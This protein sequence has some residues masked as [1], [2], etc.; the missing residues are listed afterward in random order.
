MKNRIP[1]VSNSIKI[2]ISHFLLIIPF[3]IQSTCVNEE[4]NT[5]FQQSEV[6]DPGELAYLDNLETSDY[7]AEDIV[8]PNGRKLSDYLQEIDP[9]LYNM[10][11]HPIKSTLTSKTIFDKH[12]FEQKNIL[13]ARMLGWALVLTNRD[14]F[15]YPEEGPNSP[16]QYGLAYS[17]GQKDHTNRQKPPAGNLTICTD[18]LYGLDCS[19]LIYQLAASAGLTLSHN[20]IGE[21]NAQFESD[22]LNWVKA[23]K[24]STNYQKL[25]MEV[26]GKIQITDFQ[27]GDMI[28]WLNGDGVAFHVGIVLYASDKSGLAVFMSAGC[29]RDCDNQGCINNHS[30]N[31]GPRQ[32]DLGDPKYFNANYKV[33]R[34]KAD[35]FPPTSVEIIVDCTAIYASYPGYEKEDNFYIHKDFNKCTVS[36]N[37]ITGRI[38]DNYYTGGTHI[39]SLEMEFDPV[40][41]V[42]KDF[43]IKT[44]IVGPS[45]GD[46]TH[47][48]KMLIKKKGLTM[49]C[50]LNYYMGNV[51]GIMFSLNGPSVVSYLDV[52]L[53][54]NNRELVGMN[55][56]VSVV[57]LKEL[58]GGQSSSMSFFFPLN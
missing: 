13:L 58:I 5:S 56:V 28:F 26:L 53:E 47:Y 20:P 12:P 6:L 16:Q 30:S 57:K 17:Y 1:H 37:K 21:C 8:L 49:Q 40:L 46:Y 45:I 9:D 33:L 10:I 43:R 34:I 14:L 24:K 4:D 39:D 52:T 48:E 50:Q 2:S 11:N 44:D 27:A 15:E 31:R 18:S 32:V 38:V 51:D 42:I 19:G 41:L 25:H 7:S 23:F 36:G 35:M 3:L 54:G 55:Y 22:T 29:G